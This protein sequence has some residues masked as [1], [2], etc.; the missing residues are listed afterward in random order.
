MR[1]RILAALSAC[2]LLGGCAESIES[3]SEIS[4]S[5]LSDIDASDAIETIETSETA[6]DNSAFSGLIKSG[7]LQFGSTLSCLNRNGL[8]CS[9]QDCMVYS[10]ENGNMLLST[11]DSK[12]VLLEGIYPKCINIMNDTVY[13][14]DGRD[15]SICSVDMNGENYNQL[16][17]DCVLFFAM[18]DKGMIYLNDYNELHISSDGS[19]RLITD[20]QGVW[21]DCYGEWL[22]YTEFQSGC[23]VMPDNTI[24]GEYSRLLD[25]GFYPTVHRDWL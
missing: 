9:T 19:T 22:I 2:L 14:I 10:E 7:E 8:I 17:A 25:Y 18:S 15:N 13:F 20:K 11:D 5:A 21:V 6:V 16:V 4:G 1:Y 23:A 3:S 12:K 24:S